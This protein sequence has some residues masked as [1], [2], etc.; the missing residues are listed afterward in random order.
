[1]VV[2]RAGREAIVRDT[3]LPALKKM[4]DR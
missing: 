2:T 4:T 3:V 1:M